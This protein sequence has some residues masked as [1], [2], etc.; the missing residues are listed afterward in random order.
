M[1]ETICYLTIFIVEI[2]TS[3]LFFE[4]KFNRKLIFNLVILFSIC[5]L[6]ISFAVN[7]LSIFVVNVV[8]FFTVNFIILFFGYESKIQSCV[9]NISLLIVYMIV[10]EL[11]VL[12][13]S[14]LIPKSYPN[15]MIPLF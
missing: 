3:I 1:I 15:I 14:S 10:T 8:V 12:Y 9:F 13:S 11:I 6:I 2:M 4:T 7:M 5:A